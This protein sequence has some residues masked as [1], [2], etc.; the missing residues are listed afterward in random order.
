MNDIDK[1]KAL[2]DE[3]S[4]KSVSAEIFLISIDETDTQEWHSHCDVEIFGLNSDRF[5][6]VS[7]TTNFHEW[8]EICVGDTVMTP[9]GEGKAL[10]QGFSCDI[11]IDGLMHT[12]ERHEI[13]LLKEAG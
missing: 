1:I 7:F 5:R 2:L 3:P 12:Y 4:V 6:L 13:A 11:L 10:E 9:H 8:P